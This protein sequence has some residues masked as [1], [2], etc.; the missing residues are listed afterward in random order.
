VPEDRRQ[1]KSKYTVDRNIPGAFEGETVTRRRFMTGATHTA[2][3]IAAGAFALPAIGFALGPIFKKHDVPWQDVGAVG[4]FPDN[5]YIPKTITIVE[6]I[7]EAGRSTA[8]IRQRNPQIDID[9]PDRYNRY[10]A[11]ST[12]CMHL[13]CPV[14]YRSAAQRF[15][16]PC[17]G[18]VYD[19]LGQVTGGPPVRPL[20]RFYTREVNGRV[21]IG[22]RYSVNRELRRFSPRDPGEPL[23]G[24]GQYLY[25]SRPSVRKIPGT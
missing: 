21:Q 13:G 24:I 5:T 22:P 25:P 10:I 18:G 7:G 6:G 1:S 8:Y 19:F 9:K 3:A 23:D 17:H 14:A 4:D 11:I 16:C 15:I 20:D 12:R 2:G